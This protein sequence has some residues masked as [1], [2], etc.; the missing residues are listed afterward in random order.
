MRK[1]PLF[2]A[3]IGL[4]F[5]CS[6]K[7]SN[8]AHNNNGSGAN[9]W[10]SSITSYS[11]SDQESIVDSF[12]YDSAHRL[13]SYQQ[14]GYDTS[15]GYAY[16]ASWSAIFSLPAGSTA[17]P[18][19]YTNDLT[20]T[21]ELHQLSY[22]AQGRIIK[23]SSLG[24]SGWVIYFGYPNNN[25][26]F[27]AYYDGTIANSLLDTLFMSNGNISSYHVYLPNNDL[28]AD[29]LEGNVKAGYSGLANPCYHS[30]ITSSIGPLIYAL[31]ISGYGGNFDAI[32]QKALNS[33]SGLVDGLPFNTTVT[34]TQV[35]DSQGRLARESASLGGSSGIITYRY[36]PQ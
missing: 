26:A 18:A 8:S 10:V 6:C 3:V 32:S 5:F 12:A 24:T 9:S 7:K 34:Y 14:F 19:T 4:L 35:T 33:V 1:L 17:P 16:S 23:D 11:P 36:Y 20:G 30:V 15:G 21:Q 27:N 13:A 2:P 25:I 28:T 29:S 22:D 31:A